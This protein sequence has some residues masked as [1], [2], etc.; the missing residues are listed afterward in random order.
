[1][2]G[3]SAVEPLLQ[4]LKHLLGVSPNLVV[5]ESV[6]VR[7]GER[8]AAAGNEYKNLVEA[9]FKKQRVPDAEL[10]LEWQRSDV[11]PG[12]MHVHRMVPRSM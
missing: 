1:M 9:I 12:E 2:Y 5:L 4:T 3:Q 11:I 7:S 10:D 8:N 6:T